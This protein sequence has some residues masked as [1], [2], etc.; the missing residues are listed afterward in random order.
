LVAPIVNGQADVVIGDRQTWSLPHFGFF[1]RVLQRAGSYLVGRLS[2]AWVPDAVSGFRAFSRDAALRLNVVTTFSYTI[3]TLIQAGRSRLAIVSVPITARQTT[4]PSRL[5][6]GMPQ[7]LR[8]SGTTMLRV[9]AMHRPLTLFFSLGLALV[10]VGIVPIARFIYFYLQNDGAG[11]IQS[12]ILGSTALLL[13]GSAWV[14]GLLADL[15]AANRR[16]LELTLEKVR[17]IELRLVEAEAH[18]PAAPL[19]T[20][21]AIT[22]PTPPTGEHRPLIAPTFTAGSPPTFTPA[23]WS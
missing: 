2:G 23:S 17:R 19:E 6:H 4:R 7:F 3:E 10:A 12:L 18:R 1:K 5:F 8:R 21:P 22:T 16:L 20:P 13:G 14:L 15:I 9:Y 11:H